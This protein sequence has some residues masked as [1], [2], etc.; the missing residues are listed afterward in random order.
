[1]RPDDIA[2][3]PLIETRLPPTAEGQ[4]DLPRSLLGS[5]AE[6]ARAVREV[7]EQ[8]VAVVPEAVSATGCEVLRREVEGGAF[9]PQP[10]TIG[11][12]R[13]RLDTLELRDRLDS[14]PAV[15]QLRKELAAAVERHAAPDSP[16]RHWQP[17]DVSVLRYQPTA[18]I[19]ITPHLDGRRYGLL[20]AVATIA[21]RARLDLHLDRHGEPVQSWL[22]VPGSLM[23]LRGPGLTGPDERPFHSVSPPLDGEPR[24]SIGFRMNTRPDEA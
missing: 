3:S 22:V 16:L 4:R 6:L 7:A 10:D 18:G 24:Y 20:V 9:R 1:M 15:E 2:G 19:G 8:G 14:F 21:G 12:V 23:L 17:N 13:Q 11:P 5:S